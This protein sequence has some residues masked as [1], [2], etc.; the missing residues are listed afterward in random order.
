MKCEKCDKKA[1]TENPALCKD[2]FIEYAEEMIKKAIKDFQLF[3]KQD[4]I[5]IGISGG[6]D[7][8][9]TSYF[10]NKLGYNITGLL[11]DEGI[12]G[13]REITIR[14]MKQ[15]CEQHNIK[16]KIVRFKDEIGY[17]LDEM[18]KVRKEL[19][20][21]V[22]GIFRRYLLNKY[23]QD[24]DILVTG[25]NMDDESESI[26][27]NLFRNQIDIL[28]R[29]GP[30]T[31]VKK[32]KG[33]TPRVKPLYYLTEKEI[34]LLSIVLGIKIKFVECPYAKESFRNHV[35]DFINSFE[36][37]KD[38]KRNIT[39][40]HVKILNKLR[41]TYKEHETKTCKIC[42]FP[43]EQDICRAC[44]IREELKNEIQINIQ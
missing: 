1:I 39:K 9:V 18:V 20:C 43:S 42:G 6:K 34:K 24:Y 36:D 8:L 40:F 7:S 27:M 22:C 23:S 26:M 10:L 16:Y 25:H 31:G 37:S 5:I 14:D 19:P 38:I 21:T 28:A 4:K 44:Q 3:T 30:K 17:T 12:K 33:F 15:F 41:Q 11:I 13:Y 2:H 29:I 35:I 32:R